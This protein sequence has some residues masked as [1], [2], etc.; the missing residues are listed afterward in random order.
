MK[1][2]FFFAAALMFI[3]CSSTSFA[4]YYKMANS[5]PANPAKFQDPMNILKELSEPSEGLD[6]LKWVFVNSN[7]PAPI[8]KYKREIHFGKWKKDPAS[9]T[10]YDTRGRILA[11]GSEVPVVNSATNNCVVTT[12][13]WYDPYSAQTFYSANDIQIDHVVALHDAYQTGASTWT[14]SRRCLYSNFMGNKVHLLAVKGT[15][16]QLKSDKTPAGYMPPNANY[17]CEFLHNW[18]AIKLIWNLAMTE[19]EVQGIKREMTN[20][21]CAQQDFVLDKDFVAEQSKYIQ[22]N[23]GF[24]QP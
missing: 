11:A 18:L 6:L 22:A 3:L 10:C 17:R 21:N 16:N 5:L 20:N 12:G 1:K 7:M 19:A 8:E 13:K 9:G 2:G 4:G 24:C 14:P 15:E 23:L